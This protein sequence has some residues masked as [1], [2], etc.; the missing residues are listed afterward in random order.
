MIFFGLVVPKIQAYIWSSHNDIASLMY[1]HDRESSFLSVPEEAGFSHL[2]KSYVKLLG[3]GSRMLLTNAVPV[4][5]Q[6]S[7]V[8][9]SFSTDL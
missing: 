3:I 6:N 5:V 2:L 1:E 8:W 7:A 9:L 4:L